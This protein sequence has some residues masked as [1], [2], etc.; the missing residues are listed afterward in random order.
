MIRPLLQPSY[1]LTACIGLLAALAVFLY[2]SAPTNGDFWWYDSSRHAM[3]GVFLRD[4]LL[5]G[6]LLHPVSFAKAYYEQYPAINVGF[7]PPM[8]YLSSAPFLI[9]FGAGHAVSQAVVSLYL[10][11]AGVFTY[12]LCA[13]QMDRL[14]AVA[15]AL[16]VMSFPD[17]MLWSRQVQL[18]VPAVAL[19]IAGAYFLTC[20]LEDGHRGWMFGASVC[21]GLAVLT[22]VQAIL[23]APAL[24]YFLLIYRYQNRPLLRSRIAA[25]CA[26]GLAASPSVLMVAYFSRT[27]QA[28]SVRMPGMPELLSAENWLWYAQRLPAQIG[29]PAVVLVILGLAAMA[30]QLRARKMPAAVQVSMALCICAWLFFTVVSNKDPRFNLPSLPFLFIVAVNGLY[31]AMRQGSRF[32]ILL[33]AGCLA[34][35]LYTVAQ[36]PVVSGFRE[37]AVLA[38]SIS[39][40]NSNILISAHR[41]GNFI[42]NVRTS[43]NRDDIGVR[44]ADKL[45]VEIHIMRELGIKDRKIG[46]AEIVRLLRQQ[47]V[48]TIVAQTGYLSDQPSMQNFQKMLDAN[49]QVERVA[50]VPLHG[51]TDTTE[52]ELVIYRMRTP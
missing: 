35:Q 25:L 28:L 47:H 42:Y 7:Y 12:L 23:C 34:F 37:A 26:F 5:H 52:K 11:G 51:A 4:F 20:H 45:F 1:R 32:I 3:N 15:T 41:D 40:P 22:R 16:C 44:R 39:P 50:T 49:E 6:G 30:M 48:Q 10:F 33:L 31:M 2:I 46:E 21:F 36:V 29:W 14:A 17:I 24:V 38:E 43:G 9:L 8:L 18:D 27:A 19:L 13:R